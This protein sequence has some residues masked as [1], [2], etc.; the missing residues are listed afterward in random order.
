VDVLAEFSNKEGVFEKYR[1]DSQAFLYRIRET[2]NANTQVKKVGAR[3]QAVRLFYT[4]GLHVD[5]APVFEWSGDGGF[6]LPSGSGERM[7]CRPT[8]DDLTTT[9]TT[10]RAVR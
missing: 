1:R 3:G 5:I 8:R 4:D 7:T 2:L 10:A 9:R 6:G